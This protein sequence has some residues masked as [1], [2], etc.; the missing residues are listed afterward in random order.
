MGG[1]LPLG[2]DRHPDPQ[3]RE[4]VVNPAEAEVVKMLFR[5]Y[6]DLNN[7]RL[8]EVEAERRGLRPKTLVSRTGRV[9]GGSPF[10]RGQLHHLLTNPVYIGRIR[11]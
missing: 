6:A 4:L 2:Y 3:R 8:V 9:R 10:A 7:L 11:H 1:A 5:L